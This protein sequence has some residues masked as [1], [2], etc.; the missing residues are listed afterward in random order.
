M[1]ATR[2]HIPLR[3]GISAAG[4]LV[5]AVVIDDRDD[6]VSI[7]TAAGGRGDLDS[8][9]R[10]ALEQV[11]AAE[12]GLAM[13][14]TT[15]F[16]D[17]LEDHRAVAGV[18]V[19]RV[20]ATPTTAVPP[21]AGWPQPIEGRVTGPWLSTGG[22]TDI[23][24]S[25]NGEL[26]LAAVRAFAERCRDRCGGIAVSGSFSYLNDRP[27]RAVAT[28]IREVLGAE[29]P[30]AQSHEVGGFGLLERENATILN[31]ALSG[32]ARAVISGV[33]SALRGLDIRAELF[34]ARNDG[35]L[36]SASRASV[37]PIHLVSGRLATAVR[38]RARLAGTTDAIVVD[39]DGRS[40]RAGALRQ[41][42]LVF[43]PTPTL[44][45]VRTSQP[46]PLGF[47]EP[48]GMTEEQLVSRLRRRVGDLPVLDSWEARPTTAEASA[49]AVASAAGAAL[50]PVSASVWGFVGAESDRADTLAMAKRRAVDEAIL[51]GADPTDT[52]V[53]QVIDTHVTYMSGGTHRLFVQAAGRPFQPRVEPVG[54]ASERKHHV[55]QD[56]AALGGDA[57]RRHGGAGDDRM[58]L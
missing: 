32:P 9:V 43:D 33:R 16:A 12:I 42:Q 26:D 49:F 6:I 27:E 53:R 45:G 25:V 18:G 40:P 13:L 46:V 58:R 35:T 15:A 44:A 34:V 57:V 4:P 41:G 10:G 3:L 52:E 39:H 50:A 7:G 38:G 54:T 24:G 55:A 2:R 48:A 30:I 19:I 36:V 5:T 14:A 28:V 31:A 51:A 11:D 22:G 8:A 23:D 37:L 17:W 20:G 47:A 29:S 56:K 21:F 1:S